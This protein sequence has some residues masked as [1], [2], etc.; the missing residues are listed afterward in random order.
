MLTDLP[1]SERKNE[2]GARLFAELDTGRT[3]HLFDLSYFRVT[4]DIV[5]VDQ[6]NSFFAG[7][8]L[9]LGWN[10]TTE[11]TPA[12]SAVYGI[13]AM[14]EGGKYI[15]IPG[16]SSSTT[17]VGA[18]AQLLW[19]PTDDLD[20]S[21][22]V[23][24]DDNSSYGGFTTGRLAAS[25]RPL[26]GTTLRGAIATGYRAPSI[27]ELYGNYTAGS[28]PFVGNAAL[29]PEES[30]SY[31]IGIDQEL[32]GGGQLS[33]TLFRLETDNLIRVQNNFPAVSTLINTVGTSVSKGLELSADLP[34][35][36]AVDLTGSYT[37]TDARK[38]DGEPLVRI[39]LHQVTLALNADLG[40]GWSG[41]FGLTR[42]EGAEEGF[43]GF[44]F[45]ADNYTVYRA[46]LGYDIGNDR[47]AYLR[48]ENLTDEIYEITD[49][50]GTPR[51]SFH[52]GIRASF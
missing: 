11:L 34:V 14:E 36:G 33:A 6:G 43:S 29:T 31:E 15:R 22:S 4:R 20:I 28:F 46:Q 25:W 7:D 37:Y 9:S 8:R 18:F 1:N 50:Y 3:Q 44:Q 10:A 38:P 24:R 52:A 13:D 51:R 45:D 16:G 12:L 47:E 39:P 19:A 49:G 41:S 23:R 17:T 21:A 26:D 5:D 48:V 42:A 32:A 27:D 2:Y 35:T 40:N 30:L